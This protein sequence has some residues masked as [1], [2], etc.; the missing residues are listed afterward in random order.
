MAF[1]LICVSGE[2][3][4]GRTRLLDAVTPSV[5]ATL[6]ARIAA[7]EAAGV[8]REACCVDPGIGFGKTAEH[9][10]R[11]LREL[12]AFAELLLRAR[13]RLFQPLGVHRLGKVHAHAPGAA[14]FLFRA[15]G[16]RHDELLGRFPKPQRFQL[17]SQ[18]Q[19]HLRRRSRLAEVQRR[20]LGGLIDLE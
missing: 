12:R 1:S 20:S 9:N 18:K 3:G 11:L 19:A 13:Q 17:F 10:F 15:L 4:S 8:R 2:P 6:V 7:A 14:G 16:S 5:P